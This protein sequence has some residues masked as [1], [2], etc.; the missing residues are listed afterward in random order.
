MKQVTETIHK[1]SRKHYSIVNLV[2]YLLFYI[3]ALYAGCGASC[4]KNPVVKKNELITAAPV[5]LSI[6]KRLFDSECA[7]LCKKWNTSPESEVLELG[8][9][10]IDACEFSTILGFLP[11]L[12]TLELL[13]ICIKSITSPRAFDAIA[14]CSELE[15]LALKGTNLDRR[16]LD[17][18]TSHCLSLKKINLDESFQLKE[19]DFVFLCR[20]S[21]L[22]ELVLSVN[23]IDLSTLKQIITANKT[24]LKKVD[25]TWCRHIKEFE[26]AQLMEFAPG[27]KFVYFFGRLPP[28]DEPLLFE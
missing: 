23:R 13:Q 3:P 11:R 15:N 25:I 19:E 5:A 9:A 18:I 24:T 21:Q 2:F 8:H 16:A 1:T 28:I 14:Q 4:L 12:K 22:E 10:E 17:L 7:R 20:C 27:I 26:V 6:D